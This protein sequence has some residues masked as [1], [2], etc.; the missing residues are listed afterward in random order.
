MMQRRSV[1][2]GLLCLAVPLRA[3]ADA[4]DDKLA[5][6]MRARAGATSESGYARSPTKSSLPIV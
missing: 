4:V 3:H 2:F 5:A 6:M 1:L